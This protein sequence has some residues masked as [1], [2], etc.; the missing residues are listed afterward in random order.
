M[1]TVDEI[2]RIAEIEFA[3]IVKNTYQID[4]KLRI[5]LIN[6]SFI[7]VYLSQKLQGKFGIH[8]ERMDKRKA[9]YRYDNFPDKKWRAVA[10][11]P[12]HF[13][14]GSYDNVESSPFPLQPLNGFRAFM[15][16]VKNKIEK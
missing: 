5:V 13:H 3:D 4:Y 2:K 14:N 16:F 1:P 7:D 8:W 9:I 11:F 12:F 15:E 10:S 6:N